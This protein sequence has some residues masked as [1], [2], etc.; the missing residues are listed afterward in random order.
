MLRIGLTGGIASGKST[1]AALFAARGATVIDT[2][3]IAREVVEPGSRTLAA[4]VNALGGDILDGEGRLDRAELRRRLFADAE[5]TD[6]PPRAVYEGAPVEPDPAIEAILAPAVARVSAIKAEPL[7]VTLAVPM[8]V[9]GEI[10]SPV[11]APGGQSSR[12]APQR[13]VIERP[14]ASATHTLSLP[15]MA[16]PQGALML[17]PPSNVPTTVPSGS[18][19]ETSPPGYL[20]AISYRSIHI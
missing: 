6:Q 5:S 3:V 19:M 14:N 20:A 18:T 10:E 16:R 1:V 12:R 13:C 8:T 15:S 7:G 11:F 9:G 4:L 2:D 17:P